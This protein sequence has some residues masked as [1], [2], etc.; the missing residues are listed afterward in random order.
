MKYAIYKSI[1][2]VPLT[3]RVFINFPQWV[4]MKAYEI[5]VEDFNVR[6]EFLAVCNA[7]CENEKISGLYAEVSSFANIQWVKFDDKGVALE[8]M[9]CETKNCVQCKHYNVFVEIIKYE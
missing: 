4:G 2:T 1:S 7:Q 3:F 5:I 8:C 6:I 9:N